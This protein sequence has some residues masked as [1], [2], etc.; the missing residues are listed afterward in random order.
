MKRREG[1]RNKESC[2]WAA[3]DA[4]RRAKRKQSEPPF[5][6]CWGQG[7]LCKANLR[8]ERWVGSRT[9]PSRTALR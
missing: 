8:H 1:T 5:L 4:V 2:D 9:R 6:V 7:T 3:V